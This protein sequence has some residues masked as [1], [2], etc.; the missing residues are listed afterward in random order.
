MAELGAAQINT[1]TFDPDRN[2]TFDQLAI[3]TEMAAQH[4]IGTTIE[5]A[6]A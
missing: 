5:M 6:P 3:L 2:R 1:L 4:G